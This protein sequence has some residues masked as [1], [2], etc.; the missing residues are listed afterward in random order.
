MAKEASNRKERARAKASEERKER[1]QERSDLKAALMIGVPLLVVFVI[2]FAVVLPMLSVPFSTFKSNF[3]SSTRIAVVAQY[4]NNSYSGAVL[5]CAT[6]VVQVAAH[7][8]NASSID[9]FVL[10][11]TTCTYP[12][13]GLGHTVNLATNTIQNCI[14]MTMSEPSVVLNYSS[15]N[16]TRITTSRLYVNGDSP[17]MSQCPIAV[18]LS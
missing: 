12:V 14:N 2:F 5:Q 13:G 10:N 18:D 7:S 11:G 3:L 8:R 6:Q 9:F 15:T 1:R 16:Q 4:S 17:Y